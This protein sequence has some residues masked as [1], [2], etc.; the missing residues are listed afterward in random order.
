[1][2][3]KQRERE[4]CSSLHAH[5]RLDIKPI[6]VREGTQIRCVLDYSQGHTLCVCFGLHLDH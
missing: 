1:M 4:I 6:D 2:K 3:A 5:C